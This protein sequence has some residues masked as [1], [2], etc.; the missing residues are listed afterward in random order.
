M[1]PTKAVKFGTGKR[2]EVNRHITQCQC[3]SPLILLYKATKTEIGGALQVHDFAWPGKKFTQITMI[4]LMSTMH[5]AT[6]QCHCCLLP[7]AA[8]SLNFNSLSHLLCSSMFTMGSP[9]KSQNP[10]TSHCL[11]A[12]H[13]YPLCILFSACLDH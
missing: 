3:T 6:N 9:V 10:S 11:A 4:H 2:W 8:N 5:S 13:Q 7:A 12:L 1:C